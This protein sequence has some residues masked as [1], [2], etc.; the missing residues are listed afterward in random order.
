[1]RLSRPKIFLIVG[2][3]LALVI[4][5]LFA[6]R[7]GRRMADF[8]QAEAPPIAPWMTV[9]HTARIYDVPPPVL[10]EALEIEGSRGDRRPLS[11]I[12]RE[13][14]KAVEILIARLYTTIEEFHAQLPRP[15][16]RPQPPESRP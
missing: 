2:F 1:M 4:T 15:P 13:Q 7:L 8:R 14:G 16:E 12:A 9:H 3:L 10:Y 6:I 11:A 5:G